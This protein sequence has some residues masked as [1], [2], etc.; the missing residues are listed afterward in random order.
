M[1]EINSQSGTAAFLVLLSPAHACL[2]RVVSPI[3]TE[4]GMMVKR[5]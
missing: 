4:I 1:D 2:T 3:T 5:H